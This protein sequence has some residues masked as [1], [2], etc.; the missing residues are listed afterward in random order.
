MNFFLSPS[1][2]IDSVDQVLTSYQVVDVEFRLTGAILAKDKRWVPLRI[3]GLK[4]NSNAF[5]VEVDGRTNYDTVIYDSLGAIVAF[6]Y[7]GV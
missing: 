7:D 6:S 1:N 3:G 4:L 5:F 2:V